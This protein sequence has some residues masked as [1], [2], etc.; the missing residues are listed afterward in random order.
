MPLPPCSCTDNTFEDVEKF[1][2]TDSTNTFWEN[3]SHDGACTSN[4]DSTF[5]SASS[6]LPDSC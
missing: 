1:Q 5:D 4:T 2:F 6:G 3:N